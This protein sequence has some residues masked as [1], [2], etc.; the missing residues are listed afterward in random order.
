MP[1][2]DP[3]EKTN[4]L[5][6]LDN[7]D[8]IGDEIQ[9]REGLGANIHEFLGQALWG[10]VSS[11][12]GGVPEFSDIIQEASGGESGKWEKIITSLPSEALT[13]GGSEESY[14]GDFSASETA[15]E[16]TV[17]GKIGYT[18]G[19][20]A[21]M[22]AQFV[23]LIKGVNLGSRLVGW[24]LGASGW[25][26]GKE[27]A[28]RIVQGEIKE[29]FGNIIYKAGQKEGAR[30]FTEDQ[31]YKISEKALDIVSKSSARAQGY[32]KFGDAVY[33][34][35]A[36]QAIKEEVL[37]EFIGKLD[38][39]LLDK[40][41]DD[42]FQIA[43]R[44]S[45]EEAM[46][47]MSNWYL[48]MAMKASGATTVQGIS[49]RSRMLAGIAGATSY[50]AILGVATGTIRGFGQYSVHNKY[51]FEKP[52]SMVGYAGDLVWDEA[53]TFALM[54]PVQFLRGGGAASNLTKVKDMVRGITN[55]LRPIKK[56]TPEELE[57]QIDLLYVFSNGD[58]GST[59]RSGALGARK[60]AS[61]RDGW[62]K[63]RG[64]LDPKTPEGKKAH[65]EMREFLTDARGQ[66]L[67]NAPTDL[68]REIG[69]DMFQSLPRM[70]AG[71]VAMNAPQLIDTVQKYG[72]SRVMEAWGE[73]D[74]ERISNIFTG[75]FFTRQP[76][77]FHLPGAPKPK[78]FEVFQRG[79]IKR[80]AST[81]VCFG[82]QINMGGLAIKIL[83]HLI[84]KIDC[85]VNHLKG[86]K[87]FK[88]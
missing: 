36:K 39:N 67:R 53:K 21:G 73:T 50:D 11:F 71:T 66:F 15:G 24:G 18:V 23:P 40:F 1:V 22:M 80:Y 30:E 69:A 60:W 56:L 77:S 3:Y 41:A 43:L 10:G 28:K 32:K 31:A 8:L 45:P 44:R 49:N 54:G 62:Y 38:D 25:Y 68:L 33:Q 85:I 63:K 64:S 65:D 74:H 79:D 55:R 72:P 35:G 6:E 59:V 7:I 75:M 70:L 82:W 84:L 29:S 12:L 13:L 14:A 88:K 9:Q 47:A 48:S 19:S 4:I 78:G 87:R 26:S 58:I 86:L 27:A 42:V 17:G 46:T 37:S 76:H 16:L 20:I 81:K 2:Y 34:V 83:N 57:T 5:D 61:K 52:E 51:D